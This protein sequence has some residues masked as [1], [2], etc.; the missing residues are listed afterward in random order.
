MSPIRIGS[1]SLGAP[2]PPAAA[3]VRRRRRPA[4]SGD[5][6]SIPRNEHSGPLKPMQITW[7]DGS[8]SDR[9]GMSVP[10][11]LSEGPAESRT[12]AVEAA[13]HLNRID[14][15][16]RERWNRAGWDDRG[17]DL[18]VVVN[19]KGMGGNAYFASYPD[20]K[21][22]M[23][24]G[25]RDARIG[26]QQSPAY[27][28]SILFHEYSHGIVG[29]EVRGMPEHVQPFLSHREHNAINESIADVIST[30]L[31][32]TDWRNGQE[33]RDG[34]PLR[35]LADPSIPTWNAAV[36]KDTG[37][38]EHTLSGVLSRAAVVAA[39]SAGTLPVVDAWYAGI[40]K[41][42]RKEL[43]SVK[44]PGAG[45]ALGAWVRAT[46]K[47]AEEVGGRGSALVDAVRD[48]WAAVG[49]GRYASKEQLDKVG[50]DKADKPKRRDKR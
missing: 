48:G 9:L 42:Y 33:I 28:P 4:G 6:H 32:G 13:R 34:S 37:L 43:L 3:R 1:E 16:I 49:L 38:Q 50:Q 40:D 12:Q 8:V 17:G 35:D 26:F 41:H 11:P 5:G 19:Q 14:G 25:V 23:G 24:I 46:M 7:R 22:E 15:L 47:G 30:G 10:R 31:L 45:R 20:G 39:E 36:R 29:S 2:E 18:T 21:G 44:T 27:S